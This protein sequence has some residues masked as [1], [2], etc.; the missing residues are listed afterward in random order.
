MDIALTQI[1][2]DLES[3]KKQ[4]ESVDFWSARD[5]MIVLGYSEWRKFV[6]VI[7]KAKEA[8]KKSGQNESDQFVGA[9]KL[10][11][12]GSG[13]NRGVEDFLLTRYACYLVAQN[14]DPRKV[15]IALAQT[16]FATQTR[17]QE[18]LEQREKE[19][20]RLDARTKLKDTEKKITNTVY[21]RGIKLPAEFGT[22]KKR[23]RISP[24]RSLADFD[25]QVELKAKDFALA[26]TDH[27]IKE[28]NLQGTHQMTEEVVKNSKAT[29]Q[30]LLSRGIKPEVLKAEEDLKKIETRRK[31][32]MKSLK[33]KK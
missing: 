9:D 33:K 30:T 29:R 1:Q 12:T 10:V 31:K 19:N 7:E 13:A 27:N 5:L 6:G 2:T 16:Y 8:C 20:K 3:I 21:E 32:E 4:K 25:T 14:G 24:V 22:F 28:K 17:R 11:L 15:Q 26:M 18:L 23:R